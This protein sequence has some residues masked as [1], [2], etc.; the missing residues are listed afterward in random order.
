MASKNLS[1]LKDEELVELQ[2]DLSNKR[3]EAA[4]SVK[5]DQLAVQEELDRRE[6]DRRIGVLTPA[7]AEYLRE[8]LNEKEDSDG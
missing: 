2:I 3:A 1:N 7:Q 4:Q 8:K 5:D 6:L